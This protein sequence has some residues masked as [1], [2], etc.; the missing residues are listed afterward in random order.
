MQ[1]GFA[2]HDADEET[3][4]DQYRHD[5]TEM[6]GQNDAALVLVQ[7]LPRKNCSKLAILLCSIEY[8]CAIE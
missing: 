5:S 2:A 4:M 8:I 3:S 6:N 1:G 7:Y